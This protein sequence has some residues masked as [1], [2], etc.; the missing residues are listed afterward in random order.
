MN[1]QVPPRIHVLTKPRG[2]ICNLACSYCF[3]LDIGRSLVETKN[4]FWSSW[5][6][7]IIERKKPSEMIWT[8]CTKKPAAITNDACS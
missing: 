5:T 8:R 1:N 3:F 4:P 7:L 6:A 2:A